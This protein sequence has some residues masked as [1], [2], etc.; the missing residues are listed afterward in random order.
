MIVK[1]NPGSSSIESVREAGLFTPV[2][3]DS[4]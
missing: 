2:T 1:T 3:A 4:Q